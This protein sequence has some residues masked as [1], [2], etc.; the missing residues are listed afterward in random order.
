VN[1]KDALEIVAEEDLKKDLKRLNY[2]LRAAHRSSINIKNAYDFYTLAWKEFN[3]ENVAC[4]SA[5]FQDF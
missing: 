1:S 4:L 3:K 5:F 2:M